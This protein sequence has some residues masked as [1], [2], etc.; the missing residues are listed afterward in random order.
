M[1][2]NID[3]ALLGD[4]QQ[5]L[6]KELPEKTHYTPPPK[7]TVQIFRNHSVE[8][9]KHAK[10]G[11]SGIGWCVY[12]DNFEVIVTHKGVEQWMKEWLP[13]DDDPLSYH[14]RKSV[15]P[16]VIGLMEKQFNMTKKEGVETTCSFE[17]N[18]LWVVSTMLPAGKISCDQCSHPHSAMFA[19][20]ADL[21]IATEVKRRGVSKNLVNEGLDNC[22]Y[23]IY[24]RHRI[25][26]AIYPAS[27][28]YAADPYDFKLS[29]KQ[30][31]I[32]CMVMQ[33]KEQW[34]KR[35]ITS[36]DEKRKARGKLRIKEKNT[37][38]I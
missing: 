18:E 30:R 29:N 2:S 13:N 21:E 10:S 12:D 16:E 1:P 9:G 17:D 15:F 7:Q 20:S 26:G 35:K 4:L 37:T 6:K 36:L 27:S 38:F 3:E 34:E 14:N 11:S 32:P 31:S 19:P 8:S 24:T 28:V 22:V 23:H 5:F 33:Y 25:P